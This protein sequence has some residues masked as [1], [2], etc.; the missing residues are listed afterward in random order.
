MEIMNGFVRIVMNCKLVQ[1]KVVTGVIFLATSISPGEC[2]DHKR[3][4]KGSRTKVVEI[5]DF[6]DRNIRGE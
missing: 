3:E 6:Q 1:V 4:T 5:I 2:G